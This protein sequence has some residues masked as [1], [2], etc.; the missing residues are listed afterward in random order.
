[1]PDD[2]S[3]VCECRACGAEMPS[4]LALGPAWKDSPCPQCGKTP[5]DA[6]REAWRNAEES[7]PFRDRRFDRDRRRQIA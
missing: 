1:M 2:D 7:L 4:Y 5:E 3:D 6:Q